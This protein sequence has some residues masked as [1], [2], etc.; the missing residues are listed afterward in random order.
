M[1]TATH[2]VLSRRVRRILLVGASVLLTA[3]TVGVLLALPSLV[4]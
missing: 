1:A 4:G 2:S 3:L